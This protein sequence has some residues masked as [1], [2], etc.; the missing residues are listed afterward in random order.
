[1]I[2]RYRYFNGKRYALDAKRDTKY[3]ALG[4]AEDMKK[5]HW[6]HVRVVKITYPDG[7]KGWATYVHGSKR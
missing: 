6:K 4:R 1:M 2:K 7:G 5:Y 3:E